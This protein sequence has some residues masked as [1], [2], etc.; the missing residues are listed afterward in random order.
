MRHSNKT[1]CYNIQRVRRFKENSM[2]IGKCYKCQKLTLFTKKR[3]V[4]CKECHKNAIIKTEGKF[5]KYV[6]GKHNTTFAMREQRRR[7]IKKLGRCQL[8]GT[9]ENLTAHHI[10]GSTELGLTCLCETCHKAYE[11]WH[12][13]QR[14]IKE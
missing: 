13:Q 11:N 4:L 7:V 12:A 10:G 3:K 1:R 2:R 5:P 14:A 6:N 8:C 9:T